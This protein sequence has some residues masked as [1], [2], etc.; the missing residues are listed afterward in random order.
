MSA[1]VCC[2]PDNQTS[3]MNKAKNMLED[4]INKLLIQVTN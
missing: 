3:C 4:L 1:C 2:D